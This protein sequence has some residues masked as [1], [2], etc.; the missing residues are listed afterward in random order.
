MKLIV[1]NEEKCS[2]VSELIKDYKAKGEIVGLYS[3][4]QYYVL[5]DKY[6]RNDLYYISDGGSLIIHDG[7][8]LEKNTLSEMEVVI[9]LD[10]LLASKKPVLISGVKK[11][12]LLKEWAEYSTYFEKYYSNI[13]MVDDYEA[14]DD[15][16]LRFVVYG[17]N[18]SLDV[19]FV[20]SEK[21][22]DELTVF[23]MEDMNIAETAKALGCILN[24][25]DVMIVGE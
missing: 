7:S 20:E 15:Q 11:A 4:K 10:D 12:Y 25:D 22:N 3:N 16:I 23:K 6:Q 2:N 21:L 1:I 14:I 17:L 24:L 19:A 5:L 9:A 13:L 8:I 18:E